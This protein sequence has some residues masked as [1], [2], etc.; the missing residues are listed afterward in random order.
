M[1]AAAAVIGWILLADRSG[2]DSLEEIALQ[3]D[4]THGADFAGFYAAAETRAYADAGLE[5]RF[6]SGGPALDPVESVLSGE[7]QFGMATAA[8][9][10]STRAQGQAVRAIACILRRSPLVFVSLARSGITHPRQF[11]GK[12]IR[13]AEQMVPILVAI[14]ERFGIAAEQY[15]IVQTRDLEE[16]YS[17]SVDIWAGYITGAVRQAREAGHDLNILHPDN[18]GLHAYHACLFTTDAFMAEAPDVTGRFLAA[19]IAGWRA[20][21]ERPAEIAPLVLE[22]KPDAQPENET[23]HLMASRALVVA[24]DDKIGLMDPEIWRAMADRLHETGVLKEPIESGDVYTMRF[25][26]EIYGGME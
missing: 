22:Y 12:T 9:L 10:L 1:V 25:L 14:T 19:S 8:H 2:Q 20:A 21:V 6:L 5:V 23:A 7:A 13:I 4:W 18:F 11:A 24:G 26:Q 3:L 16:L 17:G 15:R